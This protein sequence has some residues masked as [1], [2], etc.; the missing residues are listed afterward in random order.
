MGWDMYLYA[1]RPV[2]HD[3]DRICLRWDQQLPSR[4]GDWMLAWAVEEGSAAAV[5]RAKGVDGLGS[6]DAWPEAFKTPR[7]RNDLWRLRIEHSDAMCDLCKWFYDGPCRSNRMVVD[8][9]NVH[10]SFG[11][12]G[13]LMRSDWFVNNLHIGDDLRASAETR[14]ELPEWIGV[15]ML[16]EDDCDLFCET[17]KNRNLR[18]W[19]SEGLRDARRWL[20][21]LG[22]PTER[23]DVDALEETL[24]VLEWAERH[25]LDGLQVVSSS[26]F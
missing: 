6:D 2:G 12:S 1:Y 13:D 10:H 17:Q 8:D 7:S 4:A 18:S 26:D 21:G 9:L 15:G 22:E 11:C 19:T 24:E 16:P 3:V 5:S 14:K 20:S 25:L 23:C